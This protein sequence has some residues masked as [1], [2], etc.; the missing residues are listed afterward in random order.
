MDLLRG[1]CEY[2]F[3]VEKGDSIRSE[4][5]VLLFHTQYFASKGTFTSG[6]PFIDVVPL[7]F[8]IDNPDDHYHGE[9]KESV[10]V[11]LLAGLYA[12]IPSA[13]TVPLLVS[14]HSF[15]TYRGS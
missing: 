5:I 11:W 8:G 4:I 15:S 1:R 10:E 7:R 2:L 12:L 3:H 9:W 6:Q 14:P 13:S